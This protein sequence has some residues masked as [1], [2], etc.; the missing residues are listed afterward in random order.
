MHRRTLLA[1]LGTT[2]LAGCAD[3]G[4]AGGDADSTETPTAQ[5]TSTATDPF[6]LDGIEAPDTV[7]LNVP[8]SFAVGVR[9]TTEQERTFTSKLSLKVGDG[10][11]EEARGEISMPVQPGEVAAWESPRATPAYLNTY[12]YRLEAF[13]ETWQT[14]IVP[15][16]L[17]FGKRYATPTGLFL[18]VLGGSFESEYPT[19]DNTTATPSTPVPA[20]GEAWAIIRLDVRNRLEE[21]LTTPPAS[22][23][24]LE[25]DGEAR[26]QRQDVSD[27]PYESMTLD[28]RTVTRGDLVYAVPAGTRARDIDVRWAKSL[29]GGDVQVTW[30]K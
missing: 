17:D 26:P 14:E 12:H 10:E 22:D 9:N 16:V 15:K 29:P 23:F 3:G 11:W 1:T 25:I 18:N 19:A 4:D 5:P 7:P 20:D 30:E 2:A 21:P 13:D 6:E 28:G 8:F 24:V 27:D